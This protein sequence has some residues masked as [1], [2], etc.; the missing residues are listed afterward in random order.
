MRQAGFTGSIWPDDVEEQLLRA[1]LLP[2]ARG[3]QAWLA[4]RPLIDTDEM[5]GELHRL[6][7]MLWRSL[8]HLGLGDPEL[9]RL[10]GVYQYTWYRNQMLFEDGAQLVNAL[11]TA[12]IATMLLRGG[13]VT[14]AYYAG[15]AG[16]RPMNDLDVLVP[17]ASFGEAGR[18]ALDEDWHPVDTAKRRDRRERALTLEN[19]AGRRLRLHTAPTTDLTLPDADWNAIWSRT[20]P[21]ELRDRATRV[22]GAAD[23]LVHACADGAHGNSGASLRWITD[24]TALLTSTPDI[25]WDLVISLARR[26][27]LSLPLQQVLRYLAAKLEVGVPSEVLIELASSPRTARERI[28]HKMTLVD[29]AVAPVCEVI[30]RYLRIT[31]DQPIVEVIA[32]APRYVHDQLG[33]ERGREIPAEVVRA[34]VRKRKST[35]GPASSVA[36]AGRSSDPKPEPSRS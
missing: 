18:V 13:A 25:D 19:A 34:L 6:M 29:T 24:T 33:V 14:V 5:P 35:E 12:G 23:H 3:R 2:G 11:E 20:R 28:A 32:V 26:H 30:G 4:V 1:A 31:A 7:P 10:K 9:P 16:L 22:P 8:S 15:D 27:H 36:P 21:V 17:A